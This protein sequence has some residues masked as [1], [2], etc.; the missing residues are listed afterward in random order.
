MT[1]SD[2]DDNFRPNTLL[3]SSSQMRAKFTK[4]ALAADRFGV[5]HRAAAAITSS[6]AQD[7]GLVSKGD[8][9]LVTDKSKIARVRLRVRSELQIG[10]QSE[11]TM[12]VKGLYFGGRHDQTSFQK[13]RNNK[14][15]RKTIVE[16]HYCLIKEPGA[17]CIGYVTPKSG[18]ATDIANA[19]FE[20]VYT[21]VPSGLSELLLVGSDGTAVNTGIN[22]GV[23]RRLELM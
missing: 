2:S 17:K 18:G 11:S 12:Q 15:Y 8:S 14:Y 23:I 22:G 21:K 1:D 20:H 10:A 7:I 19:I 6:F 3:A 5:S 13:K 16:S 4:T 9:S